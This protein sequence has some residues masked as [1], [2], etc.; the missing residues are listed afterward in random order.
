[1]RFLGLRNTMAAISKEVAAIF[2]QSRLWEIT[3]S[4]KKR[5]IRIRSIQN[6]KMKSLE[7]SFAYFSF[8]QHNGPNHG[9][10]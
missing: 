1:M 2:I 3:L 9:H 5:T 4:K 10:E 6:L 7:M 8:T